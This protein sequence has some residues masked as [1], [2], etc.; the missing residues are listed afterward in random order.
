MWGGLVVGSWW[1]A[2]ERTGEEG[3]MILLVSDNLDPDTWWQSENEWVKFNFDAVPLPEGCY[4]WFQQFF[5]FDS[6]LLEYFLHIRSD[7][8]FKKSIDN[9]YQTNQIKWHWK[10]KERGAVAELIELSCFETRAKYN[11]GVAIE[12]RSGGHASQFDV[13]SHWN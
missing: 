1:W 12:I 6:R 3:K 13:L 8:I 10:D 4:Q 11:G 7:I 5:S 9:I 2:G